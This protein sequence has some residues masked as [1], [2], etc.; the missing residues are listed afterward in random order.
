MSEP[1]PRAYIINWV[2]L[3]GLTALTF[4]LAHVDLGA[5]NTPVAI[6]IAVAK[7]ALIAL[8]FMHLIVEGFVFRFVLVGATLLLLLLNLVVLLDASTRFP[9]ATPPLSH[10]WEQSR[11]GKLE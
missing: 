11:V 3:I 2:A 6:A 10:R 4:G 7:A 9:L 5:W 8:I 1:T